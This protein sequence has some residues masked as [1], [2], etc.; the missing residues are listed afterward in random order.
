MAAQ[1]GQRNKK[2][3][4]KIITYCILVP[5]GIIAMFPFAWMILSAFKTPEDLMTIPPKLFPSEWRFDN[6]K[7]V[8]DMEYL[9]RWLGNTLLICVVTIVLQTLSSIMVAYGFARFPVKANK[10]LFMVMLSTMMIPWAVTMIPAFVLFSKIGWAGTILPLTVPALGGSPIYI[11]LIKQNI[12]SMPRQ[13]DEAAM[14][15]GSSSMGILWKI[16]VPNIKPVIATMIIFSFAG[17]WGDFLGP[18]IYLNNIETFT[19][20]LGVNMLR[21]ADG[22]TP[23]HYMMAA[24]AMFAVPVVAIYF[25]GM[26]SFTNGLVMSGIK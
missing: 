21:S 7:Y 18:F 9:L 22:F 4:P 20:S 23:W 19:L 10:P 1:F 15:D 16:I 26:K 14:I 17:I 25:I 8:L 24:G 11:F 13:L 6:F 3:T 2:I 12:M 5:L